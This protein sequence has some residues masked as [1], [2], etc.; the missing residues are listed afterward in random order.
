MFHLSCLPKIL[1]ISWKDKIRNH[2]VLSCAESRNLSQMV[3][4]RRIQL[5]GHILCLPKTRPAKVAMNWIP[6]CGKRCKGRPNKTWRATVKEDLQRGR[7]SWYQA[8]KIAQD[9]LKWNQIVACC[10]T[11][12]GGTM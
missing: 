12:A 3:A 5:T 10:C 9:R 2:E 7:T 4:K 11:A 8:P 1:K 6:Y